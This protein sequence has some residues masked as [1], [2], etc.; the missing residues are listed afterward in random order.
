MVCVP[1]IG[2]LKD[3]F[4]IAIITFLV[5][6]KSKLTNKDKQASD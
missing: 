4:Y 3:G 6:G 5:T 2:E 1:L